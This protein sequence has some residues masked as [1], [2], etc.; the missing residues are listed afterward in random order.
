MTRATLVKV[1]LVAAVGLHAAFMLAELLPLRLPA[2]L[3]VV[4]GHMKPEVDTN[5]AWDAKVED[6]RQRWTDDQRPLVATIVRNA[7]I[8]NGVFAGGLLWVLWAGGLAMPGPRAVSRVLFA[9]IAV[10]GAFG[11]LTLGSSPTVV[12]AIVGVIGVVLSRS[13]EPS[14]SV[15]TA[16]T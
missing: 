11:A 2:L 4:S 10:A 12:Q 16:S 1:V 7:G 8:Y 3:V 6:A 5:L 15:A 14:P 13:T 9:G